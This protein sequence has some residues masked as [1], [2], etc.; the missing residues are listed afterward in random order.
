MKLNVAILVSNN[1][2][3]HI[4]RNIT[5][6]EYISK[7]HNVTLF[8]SLKKL[9]KFKLI[10][11]FKIKNLDFNSQQKLSFYSKK[12]HRY[13]KIDNNYD[14]Y[15]SD[16]YPEAILNNN[17]TILLS[18]FFWH[19]LLKINNK[20]YR[21]LEKR[22]KKTTI[23]ANYLFCSK[24]IRSNFNF[25]PVGF[26]GNFK[27]NKFNKCTN[28]ILLSFGTAHNDLDIFIKNFIRSLKVKNDYPIFVDSKFHNKELISQNI[29]K[30]DYSKKMFSKIAI[31]IIKPGL[32]IITD[33]LS[34][35]ISILC[36][37]NKNYNEEFLYNSNVL[38]QVGLSKNFNNLHTALKFA[39]SLIN[40]TSY[41][42]KNHNLSKKLKWG[43]ERTVLKL[44]KKCNNV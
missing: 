23:I 33:C 9:S 38:D 36:L 37:R 8:A 27:R 11:R 40:N 4:K 29:Y 6:A 16:N 44:L 5:L 28:G 19:H 43:G 18:N 34:N 20:Y 22:I 32:G 24:K 13:I 10:K 41:R 15:L 35:G 30:A 3:G 25:Y 1:G 26:Y 12:I 17:R 39:N 42:K 14:L 21:S 7:F 2:L 31:A